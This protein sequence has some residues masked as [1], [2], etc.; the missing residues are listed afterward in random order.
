MKVPHLVS[1]VKKWEKEYEEHLQLKNGL[2][3][4]VFNPSLIG[5]HGSSFTEFS[6]ESVKSFKNVFFPE[7]EDLMKKIQFFLDNRPVLLLGHMFFCET[8]ISKSK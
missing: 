1:L 2:R 8:E 5:I 7:K 3:Y 4:F 6:F